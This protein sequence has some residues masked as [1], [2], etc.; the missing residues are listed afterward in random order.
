MSTLAFLEA[1][2]SSLIEFFE[3]CAHNWVKSGT[4]AE[5][6]SESA[7]L[8]Q[9]GWHKYEILN[10]HWNIEKVSYPNDNVIVFDTETFVQGGSY[11]IMATAL[12]SKASYLWLA[13]EITD[14]QYEH[15]YHSMK[16]LIPL[17]PR[18]QLIIAHNASYDRIRVRNEYEWRNPANMWLCTMSMHIA[19]NGT[20]NQQRWLHSL[21]SKKY[22]NPSQ[23]H[24]LE[25]PPAWSHLSCPNDLISAYNFHV[26][27]ANPLSSEK[28]LTPESKD[29]REIFV[30]TTNVEDFKFRRDLALY[31]LRD[32]KYTARLFTSLWPKYV[33]NTPSSVARCGM[34]WHHS[35][36]LPHNKNWHTWVQNVEE[37][38]LQTKNEVEKTL[39]DL[40]DPLIKEWQTATLLDML[41]LPEEQLY[42]LCLVNGILLHTSTGRMRSSF[43]LYKELDKRGVEWKHNVKKLAE[44]K[45]KCMSFHSLNWETKSYKNLNSEWESKPLTGK[46]TAAAIL[47]QLEW[48]GKII[49]WNR[50]HGYYTDGGKIPHPSGDENANVGTLLTHHFIPQIESGILSSKLPIAKRILKLVSTTS[51]WNGVRN[52]VKEKIVMDV[53]GNPATLVGIP[54]TVAHGT[55]TR[56]IVEPLSTTMCRASYDKIGSELKSKIEA[57]PGWSMVGADFDTQELSIG[58]L[59]ADCWHGKGIGK[60]PMSKACLEGD[61]TLGTDCHTIMAKHLNVEREIA[62]LVNW[63][64]LYGSGSSTLSKLIYANT[65]LN[66]EKCVIL[67]KKAIKKARG[68]RVQ[69][70][71]QGGTDSSAHNMMS[72]ISK[73]TTLVGK[74]R[75]DKIA[76]LPILGTLLC[77]SLQPEYIGNDFT[78]T[79]KN[80][81]IQGTGSEMLCIFLTWLHLSCLK[82]NT[83]HIY[84]I[85]IHDEVWFC[86]PTEH[87]HQLATLFQVSHYMTWKV[88]HEAVSLELPEPRFWFSSVEIDKVVRKSV[89]ESQTTL[90]NKE[91][92][93]NGISIKPDHEKLLREVEKL[94]CNETH[95]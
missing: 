19:T 83:P 77:D 85:S 37:I 44:T 67:A 3:K 75:N 54:N 60:T 81:T 2:A 8:W 22:V 65:D 51:Y 29:I 39:R 76:R 31:A 57:P 52:R 84:V 47:L 10:S 71:L 6:P 34:L 15:T 88:V 80:W 53:F 24:I 62:K 61:K 36:K 48:N 32:V 35:N 25:N 59:W 87:A 64:L 13:K 42:T 7:I 94:W 23:K 46:S 28:L 91:E 82:T 16:N 70:L 63:S 90:T 79:R 40:A 21:K 12:S 89:S 68:T 45:N 9:P 26:I 20:P 72:A 30:N 55:I 92:L 17:R 86:T 5:I 33:N 1:K 74:C 27:E 43:T 93:P 69:N 18:D 78:T 41:A 56:R 66:L 4:I 49:H 14:K 50:V 38:F 58:S 73:G 11:P 95:T